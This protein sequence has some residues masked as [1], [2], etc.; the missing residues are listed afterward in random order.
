MTEPLHALVVDDDSNVRF[1]VAEALRQEGFRMTGAANG[2]EA[3][4]IL[5]DTRFDLAVIDL[6]LGGHVDGMQLFSTL[7]WRWPDTAIVILT[8]HASVDSTVEAIRQ[9]IE[10]YLLKPISIADLRQAAKKALERRRAL[11]QARE[12][13]QSHQLQAGPLFVDADR[14]LVKLHDE[15]LDLTPQEV[16][17]LVCLMENADRVV[18][19]KELVQ[20]VRGYEPKYTQE[21]RQIIK[22]YIHRLRQKIEPDPSN[23][24]FVVNVRGV[25]YRLGT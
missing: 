19:P 9:G 18:S 2:E 13:R 21:A 14:Y 7:R 1:L 5:R 16:S 23:P 24:R 8:G 12:E 17:L 11:T 10:G 20:V 25:G 6:N 3:L 4:E 15:V 22:W